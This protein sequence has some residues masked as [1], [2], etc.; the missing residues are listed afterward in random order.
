M[1]FPLNMGIFQPAMLVYREG[2]PHPRVTSGI[3]RGGGGLRFHRMSLV[4][5][6]RDPGLAGSPWEDVVGDVDGI[7]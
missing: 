1:Y 5:R 6:S 7:I 4:S 2:L 3:F